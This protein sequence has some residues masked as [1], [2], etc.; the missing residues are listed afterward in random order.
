VVKDENAPFYE[1]KGNSEVVRLGR[2]F[3]GPD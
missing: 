3:Q 1:K 2:D